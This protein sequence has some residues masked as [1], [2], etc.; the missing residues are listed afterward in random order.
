MVMDTIRQTLDHLKREY[1]RLVDLTEQ[2]FDELDLL[3]AHAE[4]HSG[5]AGRASGTGASHCCEE[6][7]ADE[8]IQIRCLLEKQ[9]SQIEN[10]VGAG[11]W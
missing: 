3:V 6:L 5:R 9:G 10:L 8:L 2:A 4:Q 1:S 7:F 11:K